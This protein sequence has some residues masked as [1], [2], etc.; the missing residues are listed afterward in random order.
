MVTILT[1]R[2]AAEERYAKEMSAI[3]AKSNSVEGDSSLGKAWHS[4]RDSHAQRAEMHSTLAEKIR[5]EIV[6]V[7]SDDIRDRSHRKGELFEEDKGLHSQL[8]KHRS[9]TE[10][11]LQRYMSASAAAEV[12][13]KQFHFAQQDANM[14]PKKLKTMETQEAKLSSDAEKAHETYKQQLA[15]LNAFQKTYESGL[16]ALLNN[17]QIMDEERS[18][19]M[20]QLLNVY[21]ESHL[22]L[23]RDETALN[24]GSSQVVGQIDAANDLQSWI[25]NRNTGLEP[26]ELVEYEAY[27]AQYAD[28][29]AEDLPKPAAA[30]KQVSKHTLRK[31]G[32][33]GNSGDGGKKLARQKSLS[34]LLGNKSKGVSKKEP[35]SGSPRRS[36]SFAE[37][38][39]ISSPTREPSSGSLAVSPGKSGAAKTVQVVAPASAVPVASKTN[40]GRQAKALFEFI[41]S[42][43]TEISFAVGDT[44]TVVRED[45]SGWW[46]CETDAGDL[47]LAPGNYLEF[48]KESP[49]KTEV[50]VA[51]TKAISAEK[52][53]RKISHESSEEPMETMEMP[54]VAAPASPRVV[55]S[56]QPE[57]EPEPEV[58]S[59]SA[60]ENDGED[61]EEEA[62]PIGTASALY[63]FPGEGDDELPVKVGDVIEV[64]A[65]VEGWYTGTNPAG[66]YGLAPISYFAD[67]KSLS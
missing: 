25:K 58:E 7:L 47:G 10:G 37:S 34:R 51:K 18:E 44:V 60:P 55:K 35:P 36:T 56:R 1:A 21:L 3:A 22:Q 50:A 20:G 33:G 52:S 41:A 5:N 24:E 57:P 38:P 23:G 29:N 27:E 9:A 67:M 48:L 63:D 62:D 53:P 26:E 49:A 64:Y 46:D 65:I 40:K 13:K 17:L 8:N 30:G 59:E 28:S 42:D 54:A 43:D 66:D 39:V 14:P 16:G 19:K 6:K 4:L 12:S 61:E 31:T 2:L 45:D 32:G 15:D 11:A